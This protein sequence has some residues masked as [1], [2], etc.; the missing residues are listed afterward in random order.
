MTKKIADK[1]ATERF[2]RE[3]ITHRSAE[4][5][6]WPY[7]LTRSGYGLATVGGRQLHASRWMCIL[8]HGEPPSPEHEA[9]H[10][11]GVPSCVN[12]VHIRWDTGAGNQADR[13]LHGTDNRGVRN[14]KTSLTDD[15]VRAI[16][17][18][19]PD[20]AALMVRYGISRGSI[21]KIRSRKR[22]GHIA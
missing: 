1:G 8:A 17:A 21:T 4:C 3:H 12:P 10:S 15:D 13:I 11:C 7:G 5:L 19:P 16:R 6:L 22:W 18:A 9:A 14:G 2:L 20:L